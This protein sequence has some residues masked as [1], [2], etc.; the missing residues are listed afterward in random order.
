MTTLQ[1]KVI[2]KVITKILLQVVFLMVFGF[3]LYL[4]N[5]L[6]WENFVFSLF[7]GIIAV[8]FSWLFFLI[9]SDTIVKSLM[10]S[11]SELQ[12]KR[13]DGGLIYHFIRPAENE[14]REKKSRVRTEK[15]KK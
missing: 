8:I 6:S 14:V 10:L 4:S 1:S 13:K 5:D 7:K 3:S 12:E 2:S 9:L 15:S 11:V